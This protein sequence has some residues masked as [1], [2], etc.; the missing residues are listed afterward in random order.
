MISL[1]ADE[2]YHSTVA[3]VS[4]PDA[5]Q[6]EQDT[7]D[8]EDQRII[9]VKHDLSKVLLSVTS[10]AQCFGLSKINGI[11]A[12]LAFALTPSQE[13]HSFTRAHLGKNRCF[14]F[15]GRS[16]LSERLPHKGPN[17]WKNSSCS[18]YYNYFFTCTCGWVSL[19]VRDRISHV[20]N[21]ICPTVCR[22]HSP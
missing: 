4:A 15:H 2:L 11:N 7:D 6:E 18:A 13:L 16:H 17:L 5:T 14:S 20:S 10:N 22:E 3:L 1:R 19:Y 12:T 21:D 9:L 8:N